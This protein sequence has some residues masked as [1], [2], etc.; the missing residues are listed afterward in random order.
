MAAHHHREA[1]RPRPGIGARAEQ[2]L[3]GGLLRE[4]QVFRID[5]Y[6]GKETVQN[7]LVFRFAN[8]IFEPVW[9]R[10]LHRSRAD[11]GGGVASASRAAAATTSS[12]A[13]CA[14]WCRTT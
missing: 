3:R 8:G 11:H 9:N 14:T 5:H 7:I 4:R 12:P 10:Q 6:L 2:R 13:R 1:L